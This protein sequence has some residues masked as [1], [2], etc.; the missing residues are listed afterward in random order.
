M[1][2]EFKQK[3]FWE[4]PEGLTGMITIGLGG[5]GLFFAGPHLIKLFDMAITMLGQVITI[6]VLCVAAFLFFM[7]ATNPKVHTLIAYFF[8]SCMRWI[9]GRFVEIDP[10]G[11]MKSYIEDLLKK[12]ETLDNSIA[13]LTGQVKI[14]EAQVRKNDTESQEQLAIFAEAKKQGK[15]GIAQVS[16]RQ[17]ERLN[18]QNVERLKPLLL[19]MQ[20]HLK[21]LKKYKEVT[22]T[23][24]DDLRNEVKS[25]EMQREL[26]KTSWGAMMT[27][28][29]ILNGGTDEREMFD[30]AMEYVVHDFNMKLGDIE[31]FM[32]STQGFVESLD[33]QNGVF[34]EAALKRLQDWE[35]T[36]DSVLLGNTKAQLLEH[37]TVNSVLNTSIGVPAA[38][39]TDYERLLSKK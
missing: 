7:I 36:A 5:L 14:C 20:V 6:G 28:K 37:D 26:I 12:N 38:Q 17:S 34:E 39:Q 15:T 8:K 2:T 22:T 25:Q 30:M 21:A 9:T 27:A 1:T 33:I 18:K 29:K 31:H 32:D 19:Q 3:S 35:Q 16:G 11:I 23:V 4:R 10:I 24:I 13:K